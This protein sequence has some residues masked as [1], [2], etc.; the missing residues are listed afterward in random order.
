MDAHAATNEDQDGIIALVQERTPTADTDGKK[1]ATLLARDLA[2]FSA[3]TTNT[4]L[5]T[6]VLKFACKFLDNADN[7]NGRK[8][9]LCRCVY[10]GEQVATDPEFYPLLGGFLRQ[11]LHAHNLE[12]LHPSVVGACVGLTKRILHGDLADMPIQILHAAA[13]MLCVAAATPRFLLA[14]GVCVPQLGA[15]LSTCQRDVRLFGFI[16][17]VLFRLA[18]SSATTT[19]V[20]EILPDIMSDFCSYT[21]SRLRIR[22]LLRLS[23]FPAATTA[24]LDVWPQVCKEATTMFKNNEVLTWAMEFTSNLCA[25]A[26]DKKLLAPPVATFVESVLKAGMHDLGARAL[27]VAAGWTLRSLCSDSVATEGLEPR[28]VPY[29]CEVLT[30]FVREKEVVTAWLPVAVFLSRTRV[31]VQLLAAHGVAAVSGVVSEL[32]RSTTDHPD[33]ELDALKMEAKC[34]L[35]ALLLGQK[36]VFRDETDDDEDEDMAKPAVK[37]VVLEH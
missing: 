21:L 15:A 5:I 14:V 23:E 25:Q 9:F 4:C 19:R 32:K 27:A 12:V 30:R 7:A 26:K 33:S 28:L 6:A 1:T 22:I 17:E 11:L 16:L 34:L 10:L 24:L 18:K 3:R 37:R 20:V 13:E 35:R 31:G 29:V 36:K 8:K 2:V